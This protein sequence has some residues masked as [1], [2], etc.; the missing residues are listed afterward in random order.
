MEALRKV[1]DVSSLGLKEEHV[2]EAR[3]LYYGHYR[4]RIYNP[5]DRYGAAQIAEIKARREWHSSKSAPEILARR[6]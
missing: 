4:A 5:V 6:A 2:D 3:E 1:V